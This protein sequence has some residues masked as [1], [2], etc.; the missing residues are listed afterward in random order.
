M[1]LLKIQEFDNTFKEVRGQRQPITFRK[2]ELELLKQFNAQ[3]Q[4]A[5]LAV[6]KS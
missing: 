4:G 6:L 5:I 3:Q 2:V 1:E